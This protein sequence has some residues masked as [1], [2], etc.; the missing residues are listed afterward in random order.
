MRIVVV[1]GWDR[2]RD[3]AIER[4]RGVLADELGIEPA[5]V[6]LSRRCGHCGS[7]EHGRPRVA[8]PD[9]DVGI[10]HS[11]HVLVLAVAHG[12]RVGIDVEVPRRRTHDR[13]ER[14]AAR[15]LDES[16]FGAWRAGDPGERHTAFLRAWT[17]KE[18]Y[19][20]AL[21]VGITVPLRSIDPIAHGWHVTPLA[22][23][24]GAV[25]TLVSEHRVAVEV[26]D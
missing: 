23:G 2:A 19:V 10:A 25:A 14:L 11:R 13:L 18:A 21:G 9:V 8:M 22:L 7:V 5:D 17:T 4:L 6:P 15:I 12:T 20:K 24:E 16:A 26:T 3:P 1:S